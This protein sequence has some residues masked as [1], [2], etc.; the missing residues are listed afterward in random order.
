MKMRTRVFAVGILIH[1]GKILILKRGDDAPTHPGFWDILGGYFEGMESAEECVIRETKE[2]IGLGARITKTGKVFEV[3]D[4]YGRAV[5]VPFLLEANSQDEIP[6]IKLSFEHKEYKWIDP[7][8][9]R[10]YPCAPDI[11]ES[12]KSLGLI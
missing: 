11:L 8:E 1:K 12:A 6:K 9:L 10:N 4:E 2:E 3:M 7:K 5:G